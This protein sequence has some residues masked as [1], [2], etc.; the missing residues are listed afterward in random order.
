[1]KRF[2]KKT[3]NIYDQELGKFFWLVLIFFSLFLTMAIFRSYVDTTFLKRYGADAIPEML[4]IN[5]GVTILVFGGLNRLSRKYSDDILL[6]GFLAVCAIS[7]MILFFAVEADMVMAY[8]VLFQILNL[9]DSVFL[10]YL[11]NMACD[12]FDARQGKRIF[13]M[14][15]A[16]QVIGTTLGSFSV[17]PLS[18]LNGYEFLLIITA[19]GYFLIAVGVVSSTRK[20]L[21]PVSLRTSSPQAM[22]KNP[23]EIL[24]IIREYPIVRYL[25]VT[26]LLPNI[27]LP[28]LT[29]QFSII[30]EH[31]FASEDG[32]LTFLSVFRGSTTLVSFFFL[33]VMG[34][35]YARMGVPNASLLQPLNFAIVF[36][37]LI[38]YFNIVVVAY[39]QFS[40]LFIQRAIAGPVNKVLFNVVPDAVAAWSR[41]FVRGTVI[42]AAVIAGAA[43]IMLLKP[44]VSPRELSLVAVAISGC[45]LYETWRFK[46]RYTQGLKQALVNDD[47]DFDAMALDFS[48]KSDVTSMVLTSG[49]LLSFRDDIAAVHL[50]PSNL[51]AEAALKQLAHA[52]DLVRA[53][54]AAYFVEDPD[55]RAI[56]RLITRLDDLESVRE[57][58]IEALA[59]YGEMAQPF[60]ESELMDSSP[61]IQLGILK[62]MKHS[63][64]RNFDL[65]PYIAR[66]AADA[67]YHLTA[68]AALSPIGKQHS[69]GLLIRHLHENNEQILRMIFFALGIAVPDMQFMF[70]FLHTRKASTSV[71]MVET[72]IDRELSKFIVPL[73][74]D[75][76]LVEKIERGRKM[77]PIMRAREASGLLPG[78]ARNPDAMIRMLAAYTIGECMPERRYY[79]AV[80]RLLGD[81]DPGV[82]QAAGYALKRCMKGEAKM[83]EAIYD[84]SAIQN[85]A[86][87]EGVGIR[88]YRA[89]AASAA[90]KFYKAGDV[91]IQAGEAVLSLFLLLDGQVGVFDDY[92]TSGQRSIKTLSP[93]DTIGET[94]LIS[95]LA[96]NETCVVVSDFLETLAFTRQVF[97]EIMSLYPQ[98]SINL[99]RQF[100]VRLSDKTQSNKADP[101]GL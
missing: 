93:G 47:V 59:G 8:P 4:L 52:N 67:Y 89:I 73:I 78:L 25:I 46:K 48:L 72:S 91:L 98:V 87:F 15:M 88:G 9:Q 31:S 36:T 51:T 33:F 81:R 83:P 70:R 41:V 62:A 84:I 82:V 63:G 95:G 2:L 18:R 94:Y 5:G 55:P 7:V 43:I 32:L 80:E 11:W 49:S 54:A 40:T 19:A 50:M 100:A 10:V 53:G 65:L 92:G 97:F 16:A 61:R 6:S 57:I 74:D 12:L 79:A 99:C 45:L 23:A 24:Q 56:Y 85:E 22:R 77:L 66:L 101:Q 21:G 71:E 86:L 30:S 60:L 37:A 17:V 68:V 27:L 34:R 39:G 14:I 44:V 28:I 96:A 29:Y 75:I 76:P 90:Q 26:G 38:P 69:A 20:V 42:K 13:P 64:L 35:I 58:A 1:M 3:L